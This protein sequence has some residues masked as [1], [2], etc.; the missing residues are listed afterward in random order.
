MSAKGSLAG[1]AAPAMAAE[2]MVVDEPASVGPAADPFADTDQ[3]WTQSE[4]IEVKEPVNHT[5][6]D[7]LDESVSPVLPPP[8]QR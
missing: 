1:A 4:V 2:A 3:D 6:F 8:E 7:D 5:W